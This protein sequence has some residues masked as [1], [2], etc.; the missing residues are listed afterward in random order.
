M[1][2]FGSLRTRVVVLTTVPLVAI[3]VTIL[4]SAI[5]TANTAV[6]KRVHESLTESGSVFVQLLTSRRNELVNM[7]Q[8]TVR[9]PRFFAP[10]SIPPDERGAEFRPTLE[11]LGHDFLR[12]TDADF[13]QIFDARG[14]LI[15]AVYQDGKDAEAASTNASPGADGAAGIKTA[16]RGAPLADF[17]QS[18]QRIVAAAVTPVFVGQRLEAIVRFGS[19]LDEE[20]VSEVKRL[21][22]ADVCLARLGVDYASTY[23][24]NVG[25]IEAWRPGGRVASRIARGSVTMSEAFSREQTG[26]EFL[27]IHIGVG[28]IDP[29]DGFDAFIGREMAAEMAPILGLERRLAFGGV[30][31][32]LVTL[33]VAFVVADSITRPLSRIVQAS[34]ALQKGKYDYPID[35]RGNDEVALLGRNFSHMRESLSS[36]VQH[37]KSVDQAK[38]NFIALAGHELRTPLTIITGFNEM[39]ASGALGEVPGK[40]RE[41]TDLI[42]GQLSGL[43]KLVQSMLDLTYFEQG[44]QSLRT[45]ACDVRDIARQ[46]AESRLAIVKE[47]KLTLSIDTG[48]EPVTVEADPERLRDAVQALVDNAVRFT[49]D[50]GA[51]KVS[52]RSHQQEVLITVEDTGIGIPAN[53]IKWIFQKVYEVGD[54]MNHSSGTFGFGSKGFGLGLALCRVIVEAHHGRVDVQSTPGRGSTF[55]IAL[56]RAGKTAAGPVSVPEKEGALV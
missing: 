44:L 15:T 40:V 46:A 16:M 24:G 7:A 43:N 20:F 8:V 51:V 10:F 38:S 41:T 53:E 50:G 12:I 17:Y 39:I 36:Y 31:A 35:L 45:S 11:G 29:N 26:K 33:L 32:V 34:V 48:A 27:T 25:D 3:L 55:T 37:L 56:P 13:I 49:P 47:R 9:D 52:T 1:F 28:G 42:T 14:L 6:R 18:G 54:V 19:F 4:A 23:P 30:A 2:R 22:G 21:T 5:Q